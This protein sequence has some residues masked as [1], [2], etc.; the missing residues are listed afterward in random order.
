[1]S[2]R[3]HDLFAERPVFFYLSFRIPYLITPLLTPKGTLL[4]TFVVATLLSFLIPWTFDGLLPYTC[5]QYFTV[6]I[7]TLIERRI[8]IRAHHIVLGLMD[9]FLK[10]KKVPEREPLLI[11]WWSPMREHLGLDNSTT[12]QTNLF[13]RPLL[14]TPMT[15]QPIVFRAVDAVLRNT[16]LAPLSPEGGSQ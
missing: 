4:W 11:C 5:F 1:M 13:V 10:R 8:F 9:V 6:A 14:G 3:L 16:T 7:T 15:I 12:V 2:L